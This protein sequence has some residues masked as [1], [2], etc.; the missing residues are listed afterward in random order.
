M[1]SLPV[2]SLIDGVGQDAGRTDPTGL[3]RL[4]VSLRALL[5]SKVPLELLVP[6]APV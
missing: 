5:V 1:G 6:L 3:N 2:D 4:C